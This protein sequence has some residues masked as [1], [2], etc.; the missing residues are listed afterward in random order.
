MIAVA[1]ES[2]Q[3]QAT[4][5]ARDVR[6]VNFIC[7]LGTV[8]HIKFVRSGLA[9]PAA[10]PEILPLNPQVNDD[11]NPGQYESFFCENMTN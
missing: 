9:T 7:D 4:V 10:V 6:F 1:T 2:F 3:R 8:L 11:W 5:I